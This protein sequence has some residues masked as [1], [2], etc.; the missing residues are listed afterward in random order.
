MGRKFIP[1]YKLHKPSGQARVL[2]SGKS[3]YLGKFNSPESHKRYALLIAELSRPGGSAT[4]ASQPDQTTNHHEP[5]LLVSEMLVAY[6][7]HAQTYYSHGCRPG[8]E[9]RAMTD[10][11]GP[12]ATLYGHIP[13]NEFGPLK[14]K[15]LQQHLIQKGFCRNEINRRIGRVKRMFKWAVS[16]ELANASVYH[17]LQAVPGLKR[18]RTEARESDPVKPVDTHFV[19]PVIRAVSPQVA[20]IIQLQLLTGMRPGEVLIMRPTDIDRTESIWNYTVP[21]HKNSW[22]GQKRTVPL[23]P[24]A[25]KIVSAFMDRDPDSFLFSPAEAEAWR[26]EQRFL[27]RNR[28]TKVYP[29]ELKKRVLRK[30]MA[31]KRKPIKAPSHRYDIDSYRRAIK[32]GIA[33]VN[34]ERLK[35]GSDTE[36]IPDWHPYQLRHTFA[37]RLR[38]QFGVEAAQLGLGHARTD[39][40]EV[41]AEKNHAM[42]VEIMAKCG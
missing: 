32:Y 23:G 9:Y 10:V 35:Q 37:T 26:D 3:I 33:K 39:I 20:A 12:V 13:V 15:T 11:A 4:Q 38:K 6:L 2:V 17:G 27:H 36:L 21:T 41:Y 18:G 24:K 34:R 31:R 40:V 7:R 28:K 5:L 29:C 1:S 22:R 30:K 14:L 42:L 16:E 25:Q 8:K 19:E